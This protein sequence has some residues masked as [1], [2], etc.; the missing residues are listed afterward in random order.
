AEARKISRWSKGRWIHKGCK[1]QSQDVRRLAEALREDEGAVGRSQ[2]DAR[3]RTDH[4]GRG[5]GYFT[6]RGVASVGPS[7]EYVRPSDST[8]SEAPK[9]E[10]RGCRSHRGV[11][12]A[13]HG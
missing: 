13:V 5:M 4:E 3:N 12:S 8:G 1:Q 11:R 9:V 6:H 2:V 10:R 7:A